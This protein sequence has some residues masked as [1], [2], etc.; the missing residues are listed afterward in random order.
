M[1]IICTGSRRFSDYGVI[2]RELLSAL[3]MGTRNDQVPTIVHGACPTGADAIVDR[4]A[5]ALGARVETFP[6]KWDEEGLAAGPN[7]NRVMVQSALSWAGRPGNVVCLA[8]WDGLS[9][10]TLNCIQNCLKEGI[11]VEVYPGRMR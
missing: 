4:M 6:A 3:R 5:H 10:G 7:R 11:H 2:E 8:F 9:K 1:V